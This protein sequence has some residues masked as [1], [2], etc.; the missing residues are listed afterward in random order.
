MRW[1]IEGDTL[2][3]ERDDALGTAPTPL[4]IN[5]WTRSG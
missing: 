4:I 2:T 1:R 5:P 3:F